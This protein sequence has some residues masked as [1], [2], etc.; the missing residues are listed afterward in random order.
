[1]ILGI[2]SGASSG[3]GIET[4]SPLNTYENFSIIIAR[5]PFLLNSIS[6]VKIDICK[7]CTRI[8]KLLTAFLLAKVVNVAFAAS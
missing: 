1:M 7:L 3:M 8:C 2:S 5:I 4:T 6:G